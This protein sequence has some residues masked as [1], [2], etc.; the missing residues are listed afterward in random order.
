MVCLNK[1]GREFKNLAH[2]VRRNQ[3]CRSLTGCRGW[4]ITIEINNHSVV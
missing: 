4:N 2:G 1:T 3:A